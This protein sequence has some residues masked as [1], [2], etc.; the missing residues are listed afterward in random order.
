MYVWLTTKEITMSHVSTFKT[1][2]SIEIFA[3]G[4]TVFGI[5]F[6]SQS[7]RD[8]LFDKSIACEI[9]VGAKMHYP[10]FKNIADSLRDLNA[11][12]KRDEYYLVS[13]SKDFFSRLIPVHE[14]EVSKV[15]KDIEDSLKSEFHLEYSKILEEERK[16]NFT[17]Q[18]T[19]KS[20]S[21]K[22]IDPDEYL[23]TFYKIEKRT[24]LTS[25]L[26]DKHIRTCIKDSSSEIVSK[27]SII[28]EKLKSLDVQE[29]NGYYLVRVDEGAPIPVLKTEVKEVIE[30]LQSLIE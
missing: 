18:S 4:E 22:N 19:L 8:S 20:L 23:I 9:E 28:I 24:F 1:T 14:S 21:L 15:I 7:K 10:V 11:L 30:Y 26:R 12:E 2:S 17:Y 5:T 13:W 25:A 3:I 27:I 16:K 6:M 29:H